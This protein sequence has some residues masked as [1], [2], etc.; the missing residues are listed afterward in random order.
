LL[1]FS[2]NISITLKNLQVSINEI[3]YREVS[4]KLATLLADPDVEVSILTNLVCVRVRSMNQDQ[5]NPFNNI[6]CIY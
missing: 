6:L 3:Q 2:F 4:K 5:V 1:T